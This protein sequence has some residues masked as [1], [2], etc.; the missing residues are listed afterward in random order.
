MTN[1]PN[2]AIKSFSRKIFAWITCAVFAFYLLP[3][4]EAHAATASLSLSPSSG[5]F[6]VESTFDVSIFL[7][8]Q[9]NVVNTIDLALRYPQDK[10]QLVSSGT[11][12]SIV[13]LWTSQPKYNNQ[14]GT[15][16][17][18]GGIPGGVNVERGLITSLTFRVKAVGT[19]VV[20]FERTRILLNDGLGTEV[21]TQAQ[22]SLYELS[23]PPPAGPV[24]VSDTHPD[25]TQ[26]Y[27]SNT[28]SL[29][30]GIE[31]GADGFSYVI[32][33]NPADVPDEISEGVRRDITYRNLGD[34]RKY[35]HI[36]ALRDGQWGG[37][38]H[39][40]LNIDT[41]APADFEVEVVPSAKTSRPQ[42]VL[43][44]STT[45]A[46]SG[47]D[48]YEIKL[49]PLTE[50]ATP[51]ANDEEIFIEAKSPYIPDSLEKGS[52]DFIVRA[53]DKAGNY[54]EVKQRLDIVPVIFR[55]IANRGFEIGSALVIPWWLIFLLLF[56]I[57][58]L[59]FILAR[60]ARHWHWHVDRRRT[61]MELPDPLRVQMEELEKYRAKY[62]RLAAIALLLCASMLTGGPHAYAQDEAVKSD[63]FEAPMFT[64]I[65]KQITNEEIFYIG[66]KAGSANAEVILYVQNVQTAETLSETIKSDKNGDWFYRHDSF[67]ATGQYVLWAQ[68][69]SGNQLSPPS[70]QTT[71]E[72]EET[73]IQF[74]A[75]RISYATLYLILLVLALVVLAGLIWYIIYH[76]SQGRRKHALMQ[77]EITDVHESLSRGFAVFNR[78]IQAE[79]EIIKKA[80]LSQKLSQEEHEREEQL[81][82]DLDNIQQYIKREVWDVERLEGSR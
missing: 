10:L 82:K 6:E 49:V 9:G 41:T 11:G 44:F 31:A 2:K 46:A 39:F 40:A 66:G 63:V 4:P 80:K 1:S 73:A 3:T 22:N 75:T 50:G 60:R 59:L 21:L 69:R 43:Q 71:I 23:L 15:M 19:A 38:T 17:L 52:Y 51:Q 35:F 26:W 57:L 77:K 7:N 79:L 45:D 20:R 8:T 55:F 13:G 27:R 5:S 25:Q 53:F 37:I 78:D 36:R 29:R 12:K 81:L 56:I 42:P 65:S 61:A 68:A 72:V 14:T 32:S 16:E 74:G 30:W 24:V 67:L 64:T 58:I 28:L 62:G 33:D 47:T 18:T 34:G 54:R 76:A 70:P 48:H